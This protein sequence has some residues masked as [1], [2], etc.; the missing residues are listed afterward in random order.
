MKNDLYFKDDSI[1]RV[2]DVKENR[3]L[4][5]DCV[6]RT[7][8][9]RKDIASLTGWEKCSEEKLYEIA[10]VDLPEIDSLCRKAVK[11]HMNGIQ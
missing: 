11:S 2:L 3:A 4:M 10:D 1:V 5:I 6:R 9:Q 8:P 7:M